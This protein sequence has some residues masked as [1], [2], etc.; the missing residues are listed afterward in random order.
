MS[1]YNDM[2]RFMHAKLPTIIQQIDYKKSPNYGKFIL[3]GSIPVSL[4]TPRPTMGNPDN[5]ASN[6]F[7][8]EAIA[9]K[10][11]LDAGIDNFQLPNCQWYKP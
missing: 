1:D 2:V 9:I 11:L 6:I 5:R 8:T 10:A 7:D 3:G 4:T